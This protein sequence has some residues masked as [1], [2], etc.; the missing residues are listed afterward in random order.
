MARP[1]PV[2]RDPPL[3]RMEHGQND[4]LGHSLGLQFLECFRRCIEIA[5]RVFDLFCHDSR[6]QPT[7]HVEHVLI[8]KRYRVTGEIRSTAIQLAYSFAAGVHTDVTVTLLHF[9]RNVAGDGFDGF[10]RD[11]RIFQ[12]SGN[13]VVAKIVHPK[14]RQPS[15]PGSPASTGNLREYGVNFRLVPSP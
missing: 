12:Q 3:L 2:L 6:R 13:G 1:E 7:Q 9:P 5:Q 14:A 8:P 11:M 4:Y 10:L 15:P